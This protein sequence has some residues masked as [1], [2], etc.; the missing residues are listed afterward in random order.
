M[1]VPQSKHLCK[2]VIPPV[3]H[4]GRVKGQDCERSGFPCDIQLQQM[5]LRWNSQPTGKWTQIQMLHYV[6][7]RT[8]FSFLALFHFYYYYLLLLIL[9]FYTPF[10]V[11]P[12]G[13]HSSSSHSS[14]PLPSRGCPPP[15]QTSLLPGSS[16]PSRVR[17]IFS[18]WGRTRKSSAE[19][20]RGLRPARVCYLVGDSV[21]QFSLLLFFFNTVFLLILWQCPIWTQCILL[22]VTFC[23]SSLLLNSLLAPLP[24]CNFVVFCF[25]RLSSLPCA[26]CTLACSAH[27]QGH[28]LKVPFLSENPS[29]VRSSGDIVPHLPWD[30]DKV[31][32]R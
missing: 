13:V 30:L 18:H 1:L 22:I 12:P 17:C 11:P 10:L 7:V 16:S 27:D 25:Y 31:D 15:C 3:E 29:A 21:P 20:D 8:H 5:H 32:L 24:P 6:K 19:Y 4:I 2:P 26:A 28:S 9:P 23:T 14:S